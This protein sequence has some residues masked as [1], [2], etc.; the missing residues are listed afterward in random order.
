[1]ANDATSTVRRDLAAA[2]FASISDFKS[3][4]IRIRTS[5]KPSFHVN[6]ASARIAEQMRWSP[7]AL[8]WILVPLHKRVVCYHR[9]LP[10]STIRLQLTTSQFTANASPYNI[11]NAVSECYWLF[12]YRP[13]LVWNTSFIKTNAM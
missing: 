2:I 4:G 12:F 8:V 10:W 3:R 6:C 1:M 11:T 9:V 5:M 13:K 7:N